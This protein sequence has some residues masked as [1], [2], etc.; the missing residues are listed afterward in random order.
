MAAAAR[1]NACSNPTD[2]KDIAEMAPEGSGGEP[3]LHQQQLWQLVCHCRH[4][5]ASQEAI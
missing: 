5:N 1:T 2:T 3:S 4:P